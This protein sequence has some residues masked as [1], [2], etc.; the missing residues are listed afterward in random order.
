MSMK[1]V[2]K[3]IICLI[4]AFM[5][6]SFIN[7]VYA[8][9]VREGGGGTSSSW[10]SQSPDFWKPTNEDVGQST[11]ANKGNVVVTVIRNVGIVISVLALMLIGIKE[12]V[13]SAEEKSIIKEAMPGY[14]LGAIMVSAIATIPTIIYNLISK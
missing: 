5:S 11:I 4:V 1:K 10:T 12:M 14:I 6:F 2:L 8:G 3:I 7:I 9:A 13:S